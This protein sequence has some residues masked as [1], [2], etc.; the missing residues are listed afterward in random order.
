LLNLFLIWFFSFIVIFFLQINISI[1][2]YKNFIYKIGYNKNS[3]INNSYENIL[4]TNYSLFFSFLEIVIFLFIGY[5]LENQFKIIK[6]ISYY[7]EKKQFLNKIKYE[8]RVFAPLI[9]LEFPLIL[10]LLIVIFFIKKSIFLN[11]GIFL[12]SIFLG[13]FIK[14]FSLYKNILKMDLPEKQNDSIIRNIN[15][16]LLSKEVSLNMGQIYSK[17]LIPYLFFILPFITPLFIKEIFYIIPNYDLEKI[18]IIIFLSFFTILVRYFIL[19][20]NFYFDKI[21]LYNFLFVLIKCLLCI[22]LIALNIYLNTNIYLFLFTIM[23]TSFIIP[24]HPHELR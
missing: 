21:R 4:S 8:Y 1:F 14:L 19:R 20:D 17:I 15:F 11:V 10:I 5:F 12:F 7:L 9:F 6:N 18:L 2:C 16:K 22:F 13:Q 23:I 24:W 3:I